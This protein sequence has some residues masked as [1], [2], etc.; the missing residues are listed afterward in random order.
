MNDTFFRI[1]NTSN[2]IQPQYFD[3]DKYSA[4]NYDGYD[5]AKIDICFTNGMAFVV[6][7]VSSGT[8]TNVTDLMNET[9][10]TFY[11]LT[12]YQYCPP[13]YY[14]G[15]YNVTQNGTSD[16]A[17]PNASVNIP[18]SSSNTFNETNS[19]AFVKGTLAANTNIIHKYYFNTS[20]AENLT[21][22]TINLSW[23]DYTKDV[24]LYLFDSS[25]NLLARSV[26]NYSKE[27]IYRKLPETPD[28]WEISIWGNVSSDQNYVANMYFTTLN[29]T[30]ASN[31]NQEISS[32]DFG[33][34][35]PE[36]NESN[37]LN[38][39]LSNID[40][41]V[42]TGVKER[43]EVYRVET[44]NSKN[45]TGDYYFLVPHFAEK[46]KTKIEWTGGTRWYISLNDS[47]G[48]FKG[49]SSEKYKTGNKTNTTQEENVLYSGTINTD[50]DG[51]WKLTVGN[52]SGIS[53]D[54]Y[55]ITVHV[56]YDSSVWVSSDY[57]SAGF[58]FNSST[59]SDNSSKN[60]SLQITLPSTNISKG[61][62]EGFVDYYKPTEWILRIPI[63]FSVKAGTLLIND[64]L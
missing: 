11:S 44:W 54:K 20:L 24:D 22:V 26:E 39:T 3:G 42:W 61:T 5:S 43:S 16:Y 21:G 17:Q 55:N 23:G 57:P 60:V 47:N 50:N 51:L 35:D 33:G 34:L 52:V 28:M 62:Y 38:I 59:G 18:I 15:Y 27:E 56:W 63:S 31:P 29:V 58:D 1:H 48:N 49:N 37:R 41:K 4:S 46:V 6:R 64:T 9:N 19:K 2:A 25:G 40:T 10:E 14:F 8:Y 32:H 13:G 53:D 36:N 12:A 45:V 7:N 30:N